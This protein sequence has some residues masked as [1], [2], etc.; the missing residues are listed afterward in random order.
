M[1]DILRALGL[2]KRPSDIVNENPSLIAK[3]PGMALAPLLDGIGHRAGLS[4]A[5]APS[6]EDL[7]AQAPQNSQDI[8]VNGDPWKEKKPN[9]WSFLADAIGHHYGMGE[10]GTK[11]LDDYNVHDAMQG[12]QQDPE[13]AIRRLNRIEG[14]QDDAW[15][16]F[17]TYS[18]NKRST[19]S[20]ER[21]NNVF[22]LKKEA[23]V[24]DRVAGMMGA[25]Q[26]GD[27]EGYK[28]MRDRGVAYAQGKGVDLTADLPDNGDQLDVEGLRYGQIKPYQQERLEDF[29]VQEKGRNSRAAVAEAGRNDRTALVEG[30]RNSRAAVAEA[31]KNNRGSAVLAARREQF[32]KTHPGATAGLRVSKSSG[33]RTSDQ[34]LKKP[35][36][37]DT[38]FSSDMSKVTKFQ[39]GKWVHGQRGADGRFH[40]ID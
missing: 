32:A 18:D 34:I 17:N 38:L 36:E 9:L 21:M 13:A 6:P 5:T 8:V 15:S 3:D 7:Q 40:P 20:Q 31:G 29:D 28:R 35:K 4:D 37:G 19:D 39:G 26:P 2:G 16:K 12:F 23:F 27:K 14:H 22:D 1:G 33:G 10:V 11:K 25:V 30:G 24:R